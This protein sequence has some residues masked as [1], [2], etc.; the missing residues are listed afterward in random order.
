MVDVYLRDGKCW[1]IVGDETLPVEEMFDSEGE[2][3]TVLDDA[4]TVVAGPDKRGYWLTIEL[5]GPLGNVH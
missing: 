3:T 5:Q 1:A 2:D 4:V